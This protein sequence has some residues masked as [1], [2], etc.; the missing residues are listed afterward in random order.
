M[1]KEDAE[2]LFVDS[3]LRDRLDEAKSSSIEDAAELAQLW[4][5]L[6][7]LPAA[8]TERAQDR[9][10]ETLSELK[11]KERVQLGRDVVPFGSRWTQTAVSWAGIA[12]VFAMGMLVGSRFFQNQGSSSSADGIAYHQDLDTLRA[13]A[14]LQNDSP[15]NRLR[16]VYEFAE[17][18][19]QAALV[20]SALLRSA[21]SDESV[22]VRVASLQVLERYM[23]DIFVRDELR[24]LL[25][26][27]QSPLVKVHLIRTLL[28]VK[29]AAMI[30]FLEKI[31]TDP[32]EHRLT[33]EQAIEALGE[34]KGEPS[35]VRATAMENPQLV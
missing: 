33:R 18:D 1:N 7:Q 28:K 15:S 27:P 23:D 25:D 3:L 20:V 16:G 35:T 29:D 21:R 26:E 31:S 11:R 13:L 4:D 8:S 6:G 17:S 10:A 12:A 24:Q 30:P 2:E 34:L 5:R 32:N 14:L 19:S 9:F 22:N